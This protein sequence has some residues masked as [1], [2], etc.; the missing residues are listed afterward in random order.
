MIWWWTGR[1]VMQQSMGLQSWTWL[2][3]WTELLMSFPGGA[4]GKE[5]ACQCRSMRDEDSVPGWGRS[6]GEGNGN[7][8]W[9]SCLENPMDRGAR[10]AIVH[11]LLKSRTP[12][13]N[14][15][16]LWG[17]KEDMHTD[18]TKI[19]G[20]MWCKHSAVRDQK[21]ERSSLDFVLEILLKRVWHLS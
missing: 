14:Y 21:G 19:Q 6:P 8:L 1:P 12:L 15:I 20:S 18:Y 3:D 11:E 4:S 7:P 16:F 17:R 13:S 5:S 2:A 9:Y 10:Q